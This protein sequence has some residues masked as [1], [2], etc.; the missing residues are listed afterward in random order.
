MTPWLWVGSAAPV[1]QGPCELSPCA[2]L[3]VNTGGF[4][5]AEPPPQQMSCVISV[6]TEAYRKIFNCFLL[7]LGHQKLKSW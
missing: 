2:H 1:W 5:K 7:G 3:L 4:L 6:I